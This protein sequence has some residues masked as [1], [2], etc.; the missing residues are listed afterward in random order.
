[1]NK[2][3]SPEQKICV[4]TGGSSGIGFSTA[5]RII[6][7]GYR[8]ILPCRDKDTCLRTFS[9]ITNLIG[10]KDIT[11]ENLYTP[12]MDLSDIKSIDKFVEN[13]I[14]EYQR[15][16]ILIL[17]AGLQYTGSK[18]PRF[19]SQGIE[20]TVAVNHFAHHYLA[21]RLLPFITKSSC[22]RIIITSSEVHNPDSPG[23]RIG[24]AA[25]LSN[26]E[27]LKQGI[28][29]SM[30]DGEMNFNADKAYKDSKLCNILFAK[31]LSK[32]F[33]LKEIKCPVIAWAP[34]LIIPRT[35][36]GFFRYSRQNNQLGQYLFAFFAR[37]I[38][39]I[40]TET[41]KAGEYLHDLVIN[42]KYDKYDFIYMSNRL[43]G[44]SKFLFGEEQVSK[45]ANN[46]KL[47]KLLWDLTCQMLEIDS[48]YINTLNS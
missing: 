26:L 35:S 2:I 3:I 11:G 38:F 23:G 31:E 20:L 41:T 15:I 10:D 16:D 12:I 29:F 36:S 9:Q 46:Q 17:N 42:N 7:S 14:E 37:D 18:Y 22:P 28:G 6:L 27:G 13:I 33:K 5:Q 47:S 34:G 40:T 43:V 4:L 21:F 25:K 39:K 24:R 1:M 44:V 19:S 30:L 32:R 48:N 45:E 8:L